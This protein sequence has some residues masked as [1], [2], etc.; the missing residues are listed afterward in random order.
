MMP[1]GLTLAQSLCVGIGGFMLLGGWVIATS[2]LRLGKNLLMCGLV[3]I[4]GL[5]CLASAALAFYEL[6]Q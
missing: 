5:M 3:V 4:F 6:S 2:T 1:W